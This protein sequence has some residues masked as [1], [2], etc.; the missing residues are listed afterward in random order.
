MFKVI[1]IHL[2]FMHQKYIY[3][4]NKELK[5]A[6]WNGLKEASISPIIAGW[7]KIGN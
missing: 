1:V 5:E 3:N 4:G 2:F 7:E 6:T